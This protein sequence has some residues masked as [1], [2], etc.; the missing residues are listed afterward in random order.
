MRLRARLGM[1]L[2]PA[3]RL[4]L[5]HQITNGLAVAAG[6]LGCT[7]LV[8]LAAG[9]AHA[10]AASAG[11]LMMSITDTVAPRR[12]KFLQ[13]APAWVFGVLLSLLAQLT[14]QSR[15]DLGAVVV[16]GS[17]FATLGLAWGKRAGPIAFALIFSMVLAMAMPAPADAL[18][19][20]TR[21]FW[22][23]LGAGLYLLYALLMTRLLNPRYRTQLFADALAG[24]A[25]VL[26]T[27]AARFARDADH[28]VLQARMMG[29]QAALAER[30]QAA[31]DLLLEAPATLRQHA[32]AA[33]LLA[34]LEARDHLLAS[35][36]AQRPFN[37][38]QNVICGRQVH[39]P[40]PYEA[41][42]ASCNHFFHFINSDIHPSQNFHGV[43]CAGGRGD[44]A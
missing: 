42:V 14:H 39:M 1:A 26:H 36:E 13:L 24:M 32:L 22:F 3:L 20:I 7:L 2:R 37:R 5:G 8:Y 9:A 25:E 27:Q 28:G 30:L 11:V 4:L 44:G 33:M 35:I 6:V 18:V 38:N 15:I 16:L 43:G 17:F 12:G 31:R 10:L 19:A 40:A 34:L 23:A 41:A 21:S 29:Q